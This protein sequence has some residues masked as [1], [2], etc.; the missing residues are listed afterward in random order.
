[1]KQVGQIIDDII[2]RIANATGKRLDESKVSERNI[3]SELLD[4]RIFLLREKRLKGR[5]Y[6][7][8]DIMTIPCVPLTD[9]PYS[10]CPSIPAKRMVKRSIL[11]I[12]KPLMGSFE[13]IIDPEAN[14]NIDYVKWEDVGNYENTRYSYTNPLYTYQNYNNKIRIYIMDAPYLS[15]VTVKILPED[16]L[17]VL[18]FPECGQTKINKCLDIRSQE[19]PM[20]A[21][22]I[23][24]AKEIIIANYMQSLN[25][26]GDIQQDNN[27]NTA[28]QKPNTK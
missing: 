3:Y 11:D 19:F 1:M 4:T 24:T 13:A 12:P 6:S 22:L 16:P 28:I 17:D 26:R 27:D 15:Y 8:F 5:Q 21:D 25:L 7:D 23:K 9:A 18:R 14:L 2:I 10:E 20:D